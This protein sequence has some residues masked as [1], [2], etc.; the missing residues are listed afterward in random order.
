MAGQTIETLGINQE[1]DWLV[2]NI[3][4]FIAGERLAAVSPASLK[5][6]RDHSV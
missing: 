2:F 1:I 5:S 4:S 3:L 6:V